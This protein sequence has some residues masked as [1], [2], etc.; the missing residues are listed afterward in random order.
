MPEVEITYY[1]IDGKNY[2][3]GKKLEYNGSTYLLLVNENDYT[4]SLVQ[5]E[6]GEEL[7]PVENE[8]ILDK[9]LN[10]MTSES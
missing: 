9:V 5:K 7:E 2:I 10:L 4:D 8:E 3:I 1:E 6:A